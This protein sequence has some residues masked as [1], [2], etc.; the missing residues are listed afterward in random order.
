MRLAI[1]GTN[2]IPARHGGF[3]TC[4]ENTAPRLAEKGHM[5]TVYC[6]SRNVKCPHSTYRGVCLV[7]LPSLSSKSLETISHTFV[8]SIH[9][10]TKNWDLIHVYGA[11][12]AIWLPYLRLLARKVVI[13]VDALDWKRKKWG[14]IISNYL[15]MSER[16]AIRWADAVVVDSKV[17][18]KYYLSQYGKE[19]SYIAYGADT[20]PV[21]D[22]EEV[23]KFG[24]RPRGY[25]LFVGRLVPEKGIHT[26]IEAYNGLTTDMP[27]VIVGGNWFDHSYENQLRRMASPNM[28]FLGFVYGEAYAQLNSNAYAYVQPSEVD[29]TS[30]ALLGAM[31]YENCVIVN[32]IPENLET[33]GDAGLS[34]ALNDVEDLRRVLDLVLVNPE[35]VSEF[36]ERAKERVKRYYTWDKVV[37]DLDALYQRL[38][39]E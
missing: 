16:W 20:E 12:N 18:Q 29:G 39:S 17:I 24:L 28:R 5:V 2:G 31:G 36:R 26:L 25:I 6:R 32:S 21:A 38:L 23:L 10:T 27:L 22:F 7:K 14:S 13:S 34:Y 11:G 8:S 1:L 9:A 3:E 35:M 37:N 19:T 4:V 33:I 30:P 15:R